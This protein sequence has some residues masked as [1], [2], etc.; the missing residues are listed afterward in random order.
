MH[1]RINS[2]YNCIHYILTMEVL[3][4]PSDKFETTISSYF[5]MLCLQMG[6]MSVSTNG[7]PVHLND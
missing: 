4:L 5:C 1:V 3:E 6:I 7:E 2:I